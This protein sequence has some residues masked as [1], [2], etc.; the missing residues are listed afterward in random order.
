MGA[1][2]EESAQGLDE[3]LEAAAEL[4]SAPKPVPD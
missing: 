4:E 3:D 2:M 1:A